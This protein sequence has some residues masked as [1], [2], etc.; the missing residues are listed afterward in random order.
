MNLIPCLCSDIYAAELPKYGEEFAKKIKT[1]SG[2]TKTQLDAIREIQLFDQDVVILVVVNT[3]E[4]RAICYHMKPLEVKE[5]ASLISLTPSITLGTFGGCNTV[6]V[7]TD[8]GGA[9]QENIKDALDKFPKAKAVIAVGV[10]YARSRDKP[11]AL[12]N[13]LASNEIYGYQ[14]ARL[15]DDNTV[16]VRD[17]MLIQSSQFQKQLIEAFTLHTDSWK[18]FAV[19]QNGRQA[20]VHTGA[21][22][23]CSLLIDNEIA[24]NSIVQKV[25][26]MIGGEMEG[27]ELLKIQNEYQKKSRTVGV[28]IVKGISDF[29]DGSKD[30]EWQLT[31]AMAAANYV[32]KIINGNHLLFNPQ[33]F[34]KN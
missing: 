26:K 30:K 22:A 7:R 34:A 5:V 1:P 17:L 20:Q 14:N 8:M 3:Q 28:M 33:S 6:L 21:I 23:S 31:A 18:D 10:A 12:A 24:R 4:Y 16:E 25:P 13:V 11:Y 19:S 15:N 29:A 32:E 2:I 9:S 27:A